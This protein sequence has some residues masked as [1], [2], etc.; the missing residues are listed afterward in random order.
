MTQTKKPAYAIDS[1][2]GGVH[3]LSALIS[4]ICDIRFER[5]IGEDDERAD[6]LLWI[7]RDVAEGLEHLMHNK[8]AS[9]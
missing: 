4:V 7:A 2:E 5:G 6:R 9:K 3:S 1:Y 8:E